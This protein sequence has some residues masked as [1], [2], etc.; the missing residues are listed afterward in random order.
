MCRNG[1][2]CDIRRTHPP[3]STRYDADAG[4]DVPLGDHAR[5]HWRGRVHLLALWLFVP[6]MVVLTVATDGARG[7]IGCAVYGLGLCSMFAV[8]TAY[9]RWVHGLRA[10]AA[11]R[12][13]DHAAIFAA[14]A[15][16]ATP[17]ALVSMAP[18][19][20][21]VLVALLWAASAA[22]VVLK[23]GHWHH[24]DVI[25]TVLYFVVSAL[26]TATL[27]AV[28]RTVGVWPVVLCIASGAL[29]IA[30]AVLFAFKRPVL[31]PGVFSYHE[32]WHVFTVLAAT[33]HFVAVW[34]VCVPAA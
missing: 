3:L 31:R 16:S 30:G 12:R 2:R 27:P 14:I 32:S 18:R 29:Y 20:G 25:G 15:G 11:W 23:L 28:A 13:A 22:G 33:T 5:P 19:T 24:G 8:S 26:A 10:R 7:R 34:W 6:S 21:V 4:H 1:Y 9:H 17:L